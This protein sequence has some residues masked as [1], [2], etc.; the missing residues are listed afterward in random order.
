MNYELESKRTANGEFSDDSRIAGRTQAA[1]DDIRCGDLPNFALALGKDKLAIIEFKQKLSLNHTIK[2]RPPSDL[3][4]ITRLNVFT[5]LASNAVAISISFF[6]L[7]RDDYV[8]PFNLQGPNPPG[9]YSPFFSAPNCLRPTALQRAVIHHPWIDIFPI[10]GIRD[11]I[12]RCLSTTQLDEDE[13]CNDL[14]SV[15][16]VEDAVAPLTVWGGS[17]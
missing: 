4:A 6:D 3:L 7:D 10:P 12:L 14:F 11:D 17:I 2:L 9:T 8:S 5:G 16:P 13:L 15:E 1:Q